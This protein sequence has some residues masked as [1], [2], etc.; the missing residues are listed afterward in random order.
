MLKKL[1]T[2]KKVRSFLYENVFFR[3]H[4]FPSILFSF[5]Y[6]PDPSVQRKTGLL[7]PSFSRSNVFGLSYEQ[8]IFWKISSKSD[9]T[10]K[11]KFTEEEGLLL[12]NNFRLKS[13]TGNLILKVLLL[14][15]LK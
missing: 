7:A 2:W 4:R 11:T 12:K 15:A 3:S 9:L 8:P 5:F 1:P 14:E 6:Y 13:E 10:V